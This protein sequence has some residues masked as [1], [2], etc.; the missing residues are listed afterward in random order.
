VAVFVRLLLLLRL[1]LR[2]PQTGRV[3]AVLLPHL[4]PMSAHLLLPHLKLV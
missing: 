1:L 2:L 3:R 4:S